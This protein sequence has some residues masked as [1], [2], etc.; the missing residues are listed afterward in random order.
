M[1]V[2]SGLRELIARIQFR[3]GRHDSRSRYSDSGCLVESSQYEI[4]VPPSPWSAFSCGQN[5][6]RTAMS[7]RK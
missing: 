5:C 2:G 1:A 7:Q 6:T 4:L 3:K